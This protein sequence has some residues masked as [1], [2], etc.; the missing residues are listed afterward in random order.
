MDFSVLLHY[1]TRRKCFICKDYICLE[2]EIK[3]ISYYKKNFNHSSCLKNKLITKKIGRMSSDDA[4]KLISDLREKTEE[5]SFDIVVKNHLYK[6]LCDHYQVITLPNYIFTKLE[7]IFNGTYKNM[8][9]PIPVTHILDMFLKQEKWLDGLYH[10]E[11]M[12]GVGLINYN[13]AVLLAKYPN[14]LEWI[15]RSKAEAA[16]TATYIETTQKRNIDFNALSKQAKK[17]ET[18][19]DI[20]DDDDEEGLPV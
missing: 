11:K 8:T 1:K 12:D 2:D 6:Y 14:Y 13:L 3:N 9:C 20:F 7:S 19:K 5:H 10:K 4:D 17:T 16:A 15:A 18:K